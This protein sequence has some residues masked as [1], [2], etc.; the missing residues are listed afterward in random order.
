MAKYQYGCLKAEYGEM[1]PD[2]GEI[3]GL[4]EFDI[5]QETIV[6]DEPEA[7]KTEHFKQG[8]PTPKVVRYGNTSTTIAFTVMDMS[9]ESK[10]TWLGGTQT[11]VDGKETWNKPKSAVRETEK[12]L[13]FTLEDGSV[14]TVPNAGCVGRISSN[15]ND[16]DIAGIPVVATVKS[17]GLS[18]VA[19]MS[20]SD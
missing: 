3:T 6:V 17:T 15:L 2:T 13:V 16:T 20:W 19:D 4:T 7:T 11:T 14:I 9:A 8:D 1:D 12:A 5:Y 10:V 18:S